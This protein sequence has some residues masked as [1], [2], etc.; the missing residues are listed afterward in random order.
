[1]MAHG[2]VT[3]PEKPVIVLFRHDLRIRDN[4]A[5]SAA[6]DT[7]KP[8]VAVF[9]LDE[10]SDGVRAIGGARRWWLHHS[11]SALSNVL[12]EFGVR[13][14]LLRGAMQSIVE[15]L[16]KQSGADLV[17]WNRRY[18]PAEIDADDAME[19]SL[20]DRG[21]AS[22]SF[23][24]H[25]LHEPSELKTGSGTE[26]RVYTPFWN[27]LSKSLPRDP[28]DA[29]KKLRPFSKVLASDALDGWDLLP[30]NP[31]WAK[32]F[33]DTWQ[34]GEA[35]AHKRL[36]EFLEEPVDGYGQARDTPGI[37]ATSRLSPHLAHGEI[38]PFQIFAATRSRRIDAPSGD[39]DKFRKEI[40]WREFCYQQLFHNRDLATVNYNRAFDGFTWSRHDALRRRWQRGETGYPIVD[41]GMR[42]LWR[43]G[44]MHNR[45]R[46][47]VA[48]FLTKD[49]LIDWREGEKWFWDTLVDADAASN[50]ANWQ[51][52]AGSGADA[53]PYFRIFNPILQG[54]KFD[55]DGAYVRHYVGELDGLPDKI[56][57]E[58]WLAREDGF[59]K[60]LA[61]N[62]AS[63]PAPAVDHQEARR[64]AL[65]EYEDMKNA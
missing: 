12:Q 2:P 24:G 8:V 18:D 65:Q 39:V 59:S 10:E 36:A 34:P 46:M 26:Y 23:D 54:K 56:I 41:A 33:S 43:T 29:P 38:T 27:A 63:Y 62:A 17:F 15:A 16:Q 51:W 11:L 60:I 3:D 5:L 13:L 1:M 45:V 31:D 61:G 55:P 32:E 20:R 4:R 14:L 40:G 22:V 30:T 19:A 58:P 53:S 28:V 35:G 9:I 50:A 37:E 64:R 57:H 6:A 44:W 47:I 21:V 52:V 25:L 49:L 7:G 48:S 42:Q